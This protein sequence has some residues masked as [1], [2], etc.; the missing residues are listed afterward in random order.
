MEERIT[1][2]MLTVDSVSVERQK[3]IEVEGELMNAGAP[4]RKAYSNNEFGR[5]ELLAEVPEPY[6]GSIVAVWDTRPAEPV[7]AELAPEENAEE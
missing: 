5:G 1:V 6:Y 7:E 3:V 2:D 4:H